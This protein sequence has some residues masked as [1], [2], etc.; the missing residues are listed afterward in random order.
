M[1]RLAL[2]ATMALAASLPAAAP[3]QAHHGWNWTTGD[4]AEITGTIRSAELGNPHGILRVDVEGTEWIVE[5]GQ[6]WRNERAGL[7]RDDLAEGVEA[8]FIG[9]ASSDPNE[10]RLKAERLSIGGQLYELYPDRN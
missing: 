2:A 8:I 3:A 9:E 1:R 7:K 6:P 10:K 4:N 5:V